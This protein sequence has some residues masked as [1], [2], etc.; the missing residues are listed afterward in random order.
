MGESLVLWLGASAADQEQKG[1]LLW[2][3]NG[4]PASTRSEAMADF[5]PQCWGLH[6]S[7][8]LLG[9]QGTSHSF[10]LPAQSPYHHPLQ[11]T[12]SSVFKSLVSDKFLLPAPHLP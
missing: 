5:H 3:P 2:Q 7:Q 9:G 4:M 10:V 12:G 6:C 1:Q 8:G 11:I